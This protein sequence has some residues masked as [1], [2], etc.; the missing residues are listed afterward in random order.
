[1]S[2]ITTLAPAS[3]SAVAI[4]RP[5]PDAAPVTMAVLPEMSMEGSFEEVVG[6]MRVGG[7]ILV[8]AGRDAAICP[9]TIGTFAAA[10]A[11]SALGG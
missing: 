2:A 9:A 5:M 3:A 8:I 6:G 1:M 10:D 7:V 11:R 4:A